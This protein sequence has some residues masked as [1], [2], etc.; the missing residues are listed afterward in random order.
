MARRTKAKVKEF[1]PKKEEE[2]YSFGEVKIATKWSDVTLEMM[3]N[4]WK[5]MEDKKK[6][7]EEDTAK[8]REKKEV[9]PDE[10]SDEYNVTDKDLLTIFSD[11]NPDIIDTLPVEFYE[12]LMGNLAFTVTPYPHKP[13]TKYLYKDDKVFLINDMESLKVKEYKDVD[14]IL[15]NNHTD[16]PSLLAVLCRLRKGEKTD[17]ATGLRWDINEEYTEEF[18]NKVF[19]ARREMFAKMP[20]EEAM[21]LVSF[22][23]AKGLTSSKHFQKSL[24]IIEHQLN[25]LVTS[26]ESSLESMDLPIWSKMRAKRTLKKLKKQI[27][28]TLSDSSAT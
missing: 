12:Q 20:V 22:F 4:L 18:A 16:Y 11:I 5:L 13:P 27:D 19:D 10:N 6:K 7:L 14:T 8:A 3:C 9:M 25:E 17:N 2:V 1:N 28:A 26:I 15:R 24:M 21:P 23:L